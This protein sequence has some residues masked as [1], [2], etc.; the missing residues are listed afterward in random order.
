MDFKVTSQGGQSNLNISNNTEG[1]IKTKNKE[2]VQK[3]VTAKDKGDREEDLKK[4]VNKLNEFLKNE[5]T[6]VEYSVHKDLGDIM[7]KIINK[8]TKEVLMELPPKKI[9]DLVAKMME[10]VGVTIDKKV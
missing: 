1:T 8:D 6:Y 9:L 2:V 5:N 4:A 7:V 10:L 3:E